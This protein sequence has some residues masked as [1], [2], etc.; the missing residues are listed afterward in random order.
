MSSMRKTVFV[1]GA[2]ASYG[3]SLKVKE[4]A[5]NLPQ[6]S[7]NEEISRPNPPLIYDFF[8]SQFL[9]SKPEIVERIDWQVISHIKSRWGMQDQFGEGQWRSINLEAVFSALAIENEFSSSG[10]DQKAHS[11]LALNDLKNYIRRIIGHST[12]F[13]YGE[14]TN[15]LAENLHDDDTV[16][17]FSYDLLMDQAMMIEKGGPPHYNNFHLKFLGCVHSFN[18]G[19]FGGSNSSSAGAL[20]R[21]LR[22]GWRTKTLRFRVHAFACPTQCKG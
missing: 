19:L 20:A 18:I 11:Q 7:G 3:D 16:I 5:G 4:A 2:G 1:L 21:Q 13:R 12:G 8:N 17:S 22:Y 10:T 15:L 9:Y 6:D 14:Y